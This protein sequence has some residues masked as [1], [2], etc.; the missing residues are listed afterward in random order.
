MGLAVMTTRAHAGGD[1]RGRQIP[2]NNRH[3]SVICL[4]PV[5]TGPSTPVLPSSGSGFTLA[6]PGGHA[7]GRAALISPSPVH[8]VPHCDRSL[9]PGVLD[10]PYPAGGKPAAGY[11]V[12]SATTTRSSTTRSKGNIMNAVTLTLRDELTGKYQEYTFECHTPERLAHIVTATTT[13]L[14][15]QHSLTAITVA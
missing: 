15:S 2:T 5:S 8:H 6:C 12:E 10:R 7:V 11:P 4:S 9:L 1:L 3:S 13:G 14:T